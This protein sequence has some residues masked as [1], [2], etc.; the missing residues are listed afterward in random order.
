MCV[1]DFYS[2]IRYFVVLFADHLFG[3]A[4]VTMDVGPEEYVPTLEGEEA[5]TAKA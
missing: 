5:V 1:G 2:T 3:V 4:Q